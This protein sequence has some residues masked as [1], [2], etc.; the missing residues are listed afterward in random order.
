MKKY[1]EFIASGILELYVLDYASL[2]ERN[3]VEQM[4]LIYPQVWQEIAAI[5]AAMENYALKNGVTP[6][7]AIR[8]LVMSTIDLTGRLQAGEVLLDV[9]LLSEASKVTDYLQWINRSDMEPDEDDFEGVYAKIIGHTPKLMSAIVWIRDM[10]PDEIHATVYER[11]L[12]LEGT[13]RIDMEGEVYALHPGD[14]FQ[15]PLHRNH[16]VTVT[17]SVPCKAI[18]QRLAV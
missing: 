11:F 2:E 17:S 1:E 6:N 8:P 5:G 16:V 4:G 10:A 14:Y 18:L 13:C 3:E 15:I 12:I 9:P 7:P